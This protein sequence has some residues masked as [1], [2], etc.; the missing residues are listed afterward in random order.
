LEGEEGGA[1]DLLREG[2]ADWGDNNHRE[3]AMDYKVGPVFQTS[4]QETQLPQKHG[5][6]REHLLTKD[7]LSCDGV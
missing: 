6:E 7:L 5:L 3:K 2:S 4:W 1:G